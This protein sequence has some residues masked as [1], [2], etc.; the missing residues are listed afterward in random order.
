MP[1]QPNLHVH[2]ALTGHVLLLIFSQRLSAESQVCGL[3]I[4]PSQ[5]LGTLEYLFNHSCGVLLL[6]SIKHQR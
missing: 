6:P 4:V 2:V 3:R 5:H 1:C